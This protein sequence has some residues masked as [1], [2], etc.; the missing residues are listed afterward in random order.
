MDVIEP[1]SPDMRHVH[2]V[3]GTKYYGAPYGRYKTPSREDDPRHLIDTF[4]YAQQDFI[5]DRQ[6]GR[7]W[8][9]SISRPQAVSDYQPHVTRS[10]P[11]GIAVYATI[12]KAKG[13]PLSFPSS[14][15]AFRA[16]YQCTDAQH[17]AKAI[18]WMCTDLRSANQTF[19]VTNGDFFRWEN[20]WPRIAE[21]FG[22]PVGQV[23][24]MSLTKVMANHSELWASLSMKHG[25]VNPDYANLVLW[26]YLDFAL[27]PGYDRMSDLNKLR[28][29][30]FVDCVDS[31]E[32][33]IRFFDSYRRHRMI[34]D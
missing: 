19:N 2:L 15:A 27:A 9:W 12:C 4:Y 5:E 17:L 18:A 22:I 26:S 1:Q 13:L 6:K 24:P 33:F 30:G 20:L 28:K 31:E 32:M 34:P 7:P 14:E 11:W 10:V 8:T 23:Q 16:L 29:C 3:H 21:Y 25:L